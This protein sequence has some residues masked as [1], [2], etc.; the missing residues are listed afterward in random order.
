MFTSNLLLPTY[1]IK[2]ILVY[3]EREREKKLIWQQL[4][5]GFLYTEIL[6]NF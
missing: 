5:Y 4:L 1:S 2:S 6:L 3:S